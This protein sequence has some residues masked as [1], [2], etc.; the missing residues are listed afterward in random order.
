MFARVSAS[1]S[2]PRLLVVCA[3]F[4]LPTLA[5][6]GG[7][8]ETPA[9]D[10][11]EADAADAT[12]TSDGS[13]D[14]ATD[15][16]EIPPAPTEVTFTLRNGNPGG[17]SRWVEVR[18]SLGAPG[19][20][21]I[22]EDNRE[23]QQLRP[24]D[25][26]ANCNCGETCEPC[27]NPTEIIELAPGETIEGTWNFGL[28]DIVA[29]GGSTCES[30][31]EST[32]TSYRVQFCWSPVPPGEDGRL[33]TNTISCTRLP[34]LVGID[35]EVSYGIEATNTCG[36]STCDEGETRLTCPDDCF[37]T[38]PNDLYLACR[39]VCR[40]G[41]DCDPDFI[42]E[43]CAAA[44]CAAIEESFAG[45]ST[46]CLNAAI[47]VE[48]CGRELACEDLNTFFADVASS[49]CAELAAAFNEACTE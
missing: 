47:Q 10:T 21:T 37:K 6:C 20:W 22:T 1:D 23:A 8:D 3:L 38:G 13:G 33:P 24:H 26:C 25:T 30:P 12:D 42:A 5:A 11:G 14:A 19:W 41:Q 27:A 2:I 45:A 31:I 34:F 49:N 9:A 15:V 32:A 43:E 16:E 46:A 35:N 44:R 17:Q 40:H 36:N 7:G 4:A 39:Q 29:E 48:A 28:Y 18:N